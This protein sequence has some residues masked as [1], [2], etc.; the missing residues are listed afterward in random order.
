M[1]AAKSQSLEYARRHESTEPSASIK[2]PYLEFN[3]YNPRSIQ[4]HVRKV[5]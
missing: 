2:L 5:A 1:L 3:N 4:Q